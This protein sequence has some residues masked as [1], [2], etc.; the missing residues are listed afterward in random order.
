MSADRHLPAR[1]Y[2]YL[3]AATRDLITAAGGPV[4]AAEISRADHPRL[5]RY[6]SPNEGMH[7]PIDVIADLE[8]ETGDPVVTRALA[9]LAGFVLVPKAEAIARGINFGKHL[10][11]VACETGQLM[12]GLGEALADGAVTPG[13]AESC[14]AGVRQA[15][16]KLAALEHD[17]R[18]AA[19]TGQRVRAVR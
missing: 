6:G 4:R 7:A 2:L 10:G 17:L 11:E 1:D 15:A 12:A 14:L 5:S 16:T 9:D 19:G 8:A 18:Q 3:K 13:E